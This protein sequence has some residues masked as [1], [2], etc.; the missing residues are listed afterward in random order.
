VAWPRSHP[1]WLRRPRWRRQR[2]REG[3]GVVKAGEDPLLLLGADD[4]G[5]RE[6]IL[7]GELGRDIEV[8]AKQGRTEVV[9][10]DMANHVVVS[11][12]TT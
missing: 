8:L 5:H 12:R 9:V 4:D 6:L 10:R 3:E 1:R 2:H 7:L 11:S